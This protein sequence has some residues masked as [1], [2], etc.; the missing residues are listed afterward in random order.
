MKPDQIITSLGEIDAESFKGDEA[1]RVRAIAAVSKLLNNLQSPIER[2]SGLIGMPYIWGSLETFKDLGL[3]ES[4][5]RDGG[6]K[7]VKEL[8]E[9]ANTATDINLLRRLCRL[10]TSVDILE[11]VAEERYK[12]TEFSLFLGGIGAV[13]I[14]AWTE[15]WQFGSLASFLKTTS[16]EE[17][18]DPKNTCYSNGV[19]EKLDFWARLG[20]NPDYQASFS[21]GMAVLTGSKIPWPEFFDTTNLLD[22]A[23]PGSPILVDIGGNVGGDVGRFLAKH[24]DVPS[25][26]LILQDRP[27]ALKLATVSDR[28]KTMEHDFFTPQPVHGSRAYFLH[29]V[30]HDWEHDKAL[31]ILKNIVPAMKKGYSKVLICDIVLPATGASAMQAIMDVA[32]MVVLAAHE[33]TQAEWEKLLGDAGLKVT[34]LWPDPR[35]YETLIEAELA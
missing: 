1:A 13:Q 35:G 29:A 4:W 18:R 21:G 9:M 6:E 12:P 3:L 26:S 16:Y 5:A 28:V 15:H 8:A 20:S 22:G 14:Q 34:K 10:M 19:P 32:M 23:D 30:F 27:E 31:E 24:P 25:G 11:E 2:I 33:R 7:S 17:P